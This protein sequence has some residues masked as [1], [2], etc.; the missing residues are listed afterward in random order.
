MWIENLDD[1]EKIKTKDY[2]N[3][4]HLG[5]GHKK[6]VRKVASE[7]RGKEENEGDQETVK[8]CLW[9]QTDQDSSGRGMEEIC[10][11]EQDV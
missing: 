2:K 3:L 9:R 11:Q 5:R 10:D 1:E 4:E 6:T 7:R 8:G